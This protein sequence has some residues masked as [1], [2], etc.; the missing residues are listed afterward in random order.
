MTI[1]GA[2]LTNNGD[3]T[4]ASSYATASVTPTSNALVLVAVVNT[5]A[6]APDTPTLSGNGL[7][8]VQIGT[9]TFDTV[10]SP[11]KRLTVFRALGA[12]PSAGAITIDFGGA[13][14]TGC[15]WVVS[16][17]TGVDTTGTNG[18]G[19][20]V[21]STTNNGNSSTTQSATLSAF[22]SAT[23]GSYSA[24]G[25]DSNVDVS[26][27]A[28]W[29]EHANPTYGTPSTGL[30]TQWRADND[31]SPSTTTAGLRN[32]AML[33]LEIKEAAAG[34][35][36]TAAHIVGGGKIMHSAIMRGGI[37]G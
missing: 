32:W 22:G 37:L 9:V 15:A 3:T 17:Y 33:A 7:T 31:T 18:S 36:G 27:E 10:A 2:L 35:G 11:T 34:G 5:K 13:S 16:E 25:V 6:S 30:Q 4:N 21:Q 28:S 20:V 1:S 19:A 29:N 8:W 23:N 26:P 14:Q 12:S 24:T